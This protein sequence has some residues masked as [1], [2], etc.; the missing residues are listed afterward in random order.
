MK[1]MLKNK[2]II[3]FMVMVVGISFIGGANT[4]LEQQ[5]ETSHQQ[6]LTYN[7]Q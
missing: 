5:E 1:E 2:A 7:M 4:K 6:Y 3:A